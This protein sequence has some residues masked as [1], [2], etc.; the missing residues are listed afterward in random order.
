MTKLSCFKADEDVRK[1][2]YHLI[3]QLLSPLNE[4]IIDN[5]AALIW[6][7]LKTTSSVASLSAESSSQISSR[8]HSTLQALHLVCACSSPMTHG[9]GDSRSSEN[10]ATELDEITDALTQLAI[11]KSPPSVSPFV[12]LLETRELQ[13]DRAQ[14]TVR[15]F[16]GATPDK[17]DMLN[18]ALATI[19]A[20]ISRNSDLLE[21]LQFETEDFNVSDPQNVLQRIIELKQKRVDLVNQLENVDK[22]L[23]SLVSIYEAT[24]AS[25]GSSAPVNE[26]VSSLNGIESF[27]LATIERSLHYQRASNASSM[28]LHRQVLLDYLSE[29]ICTEVECISVIA[30]RVLAIDKKI[31]MLTSEMKEYSALRMQSL[32]ADLNQSICELEADKSEDI[33]SIA[34]LCTQLDKMFCCLNIGL[35]GEIEVSS[36]VVGKLKVP[37]ELLLSVISL[38]KLVGV[39]C[40][41]TVSKLFGNSSTLPSVYLN[42]G[43]L[44]SE[45]ID[46][47]RPSNGNQQTI[48]NCD[49]YVVHDVYSC[50]QSSEHNLSIDKSSSKITSLTSLKSLVKNT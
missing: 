44:S 10:V 24:A 27:V 31:E 47:N 18:S 14:I 42:S 5:V 26:I 41:N 1:R 8:I 3:S 13:F 38:L 50:P 34:T 2:F 29:Y 7:L 19:S 23:G 15:S 48:E 17:N 22:E 9:N 28:T 43:G 6:R 33:S 35:N 37:R 36:A 21:S 16:L 20:Q 32:V 39:S 30:D 46:S 4:S 11:T 25:A 49:F 12:R 45:F 40:P